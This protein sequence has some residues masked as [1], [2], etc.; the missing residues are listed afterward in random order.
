MDNEAKS[1]FYIEN[2]YSR[3]N[4]IFRITMAAISD[5]HL[6]DEMTQEVLEKAWEKLDS[7]REQEKVWPWVRGITRNEI[8]KYIVKRKRRKTSAYESEGL[9]Y[10]TDQ[11]LKHV[12]QDVLTLL[13]E[14][15]KR[16]DVVAALELLDDKYR[17]IITLYLIGDVSLKEI[18]EIKQIE[19][20]N[21]RVIYSRG[22]KKLKELY[23]DL[24]KGGLN[25]GR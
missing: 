18:A 14:S 2:I 20:G 21:A 10:I 22:L 11:V 9:K 24:R 6:A 13:V 3:R 23:L 5:Y 12:E 8:R 17:D 15:E 1:E 7:L 16:S 19:Y 4:D 25:D